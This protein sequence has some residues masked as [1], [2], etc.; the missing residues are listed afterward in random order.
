MT[1]NLTTDEWFIFNIQET[2]FYRVLYDE[3][4]YKLLTNYLNSENYKNIHV[5]NKAQLLDDSLN[6]ARAGVLNY[7]TALNLTTYLERETD[8]IP[9]VSYFRAL[10]FLNTRLTGTKDYE[11]FKSYVLELLNTMYESVGFNTSVNDDHPTKLIRNTV[12]TW[13]CNF[14]STVCLNSAS[15]FF[16][17]WKNDPNGTNPISPDL[18]SVVYCS[19]LING[20]EAEWNF[21]WEQYQKSTAATDQVLILNALGCTTKPDLLNRYLNYSINPDSGIRSQDTLSV[22]SAVYSRAGGVDIALTFL[23]NNFEAIQQYY[24]FMNGISRI[25]TG[26]ASQ[27]TTRDQRDKL[28]AFLVQHT[29]TLGTTIQSALETVDAN[30]QWLEKYGEDISAWLAARQAGPSPSAA[31]YLS[32]SPTMSIVIILSGYL[33]TKY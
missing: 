7:S 11:N 8:F 6:L 15:N 17:Q 13:A 3:G 5:L 23:E 19:A 28:E 31:S 1:V 2:A 10:T 4:N 26:I 14:N 16:T 30:L 21:L 24:I 12:L 33:I 25:V 22:F 18:R 20:G 32:F 27:M 29:D 9:W